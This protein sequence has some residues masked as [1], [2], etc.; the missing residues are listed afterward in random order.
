[1]AELEQLNG[2]CGMGELSGLQGRISHILQRA[3]EDMLNQ[4]ET[5]WDEEK[6]DYVY[7]DPKSIYG[8]IMFSDRVPKRGMSPG[9]RLATYILEN[10]L[11][12]LTAS[13]VAKNPNSGN[14]I[15]AWFWT[16]NEKFLKK[17]A[18]S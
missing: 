12:M 6:G 4:D 2:N 3:R 8:I 11:G 17:Y 18:R 14:N 16:P 10:K 5:E 15:M 7:P 9:M 13:H 1:M